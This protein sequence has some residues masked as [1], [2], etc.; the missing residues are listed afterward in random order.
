MRLSGPSL[1]RAAEW[2]MRDRALNE[3]ELPYAP[4]E[5]HP[6]FIGFIES[7]DLVPAAR[8]YNPS[9]V[10][11]KGRVYMAYRAEKYSA[12]SQ[13]AI[14][15]LDS[16]FTVA[17]SVVVPLPMD[18][19]DT[20]W[21]DPRLC[22]A[23]GKLY[24]MAA[25]IRLVIPPV[26]QQRLFEL[27]GDT[28]AVVREL[29]MTFGNRGGIEKNWTPFEL[30]GGGI[31]F[32]YKQRG[33]RMVIEV[34]SMKGH[35][36]E[37]CIATPQGSTLSG[38]SGPVRV[39][40]SYLEFVGGWIRLQNN[41]RAG[42]Y[43]FGCQMIRGQAPYDVLRYTPEPLCWGSEASPT[44]HSPRPHAGHPCCVFPGGAIIEKDDLIVSVGINDSYCGLMR[45]SGPELIGGM[46]R[47]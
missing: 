15:E 2:P 31:G 6:A 20:H 10:R 1:P 33:P 44:I 46:V 36:S 38:R 22:E 21:E 37:K 11:H 41:P 26:C 17:R 9:I 8:H 40:D 24:L 35:E 13:V 27:D 25:F 23:D 47:A 34:E 29:P 32:V 16:E 18:F 39:G 7:R 30:S 14:A 3:I 45:F 28:F 43:W 19:K 4:V 12:V 42:R 5:Q